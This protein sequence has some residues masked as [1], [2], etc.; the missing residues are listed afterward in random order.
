MFVVQGPEERRRSRSPS[1]SR[2]RKRSRSR[3][4]GGRRRTQSPK[5][6]E[7]ITSFSCEVPGEGGAGAGGGR[8]PAAQK[9]VLEADD[10]EEDGI[11]MGFFPHLHDARKLLKDSSESSRS[12]S[13]ERSSLL[14]VAPE[15]SKEVRHTQSHLFGR[16]V[17]MCSSLWCVLWSHRRRF[18]MQMKAF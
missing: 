15:L 6:T 9:D 5:K 8:E 10:Y 18:D 17:R 12:P 11:L 13:A 14:E 1:P 4:R 2:G 16:L 7:F 3:E